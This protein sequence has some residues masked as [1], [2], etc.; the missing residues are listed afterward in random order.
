[1]K[2]SFLPL[3]FLLLSCLVFRSAHAQTIAARVLDK[4]GAPLYGANVVLLDSS[5]SKLVKA[6]LTDSAG[7][8][9]IASVAE[10]IYV[11]RAMMVGYNTYTSPKIEIPLKKE[12]P[13]IIM[14]HAEMKE[15][16]VTHQKPFIEVKPDKLIVN[17][18]NSI[19]SAGGT[20]L[21]IL[22]RSPGVVV[23]QNDNISLKGKGGVNVMIDG[24]NVPVSAA[25]LANMLKN[26]PANSID[27]IEI[28]SNPSARYDAEGNGIINIVT[29]KGQKLGFNGSVNAS[30][31]RGYYHK[32]NTG[33][34][35]NYRNEKISLYSNY[36]YSDREGFNHLVLTRRYY[37]RKA[38]ESPF[39]KYDQDHDAVFPFKTHSAGGG[40]DYKISS[41][42]SVGFG[43]SGSLSRLDSRSIVHST[44]TDTNNKV[45]SSFRTIN[46]AGSRW[47][48][49][50]A[51]AY[52]KHTL[53]STGKEIS[54]DMDYARYP[55]LN[56]QQLNTDYFNAEGN[57]SRPTYILKGDIEGYTQI[58]AIKSDYVHPLSKGRRLEA[59]VKSSYVITDNEPIFHD[60]SNAGAPIY[61]TGKSNHYIYRE[62]INAAYVNANKDGEKWSYQLGL[63]IEQTILKGEQLIT[64]DVMRRNYA[65][66]FP[67]AAVQRTINQSHTLGISL[68]RRIQRP[69]YD[70][71]NPFRYYMD[72]STFTEG[73]PFLV[74]EISYSA[75]LSH[76]FKQ[77]FVTSL[78]YSR[79]K[80]VI[81]EVLLPYPGN[82]TVQTTRNISTRDYY[83][84]SGT[85]PF[86]VYKWW[87]AMVNFN[88]YYS[89]YNGTFENTQLDRGMPTYNVYVS[90]KLNLPLCITGEVS[91]IYNAAQVYGFMEMKPTWMLN[92][93]LS[94]NF[95][96]KKG[97]IRLNATDIFWRGYPRAVSYYSNYNE[98]F[99]AY[100]DTRVVTLAVTY[101][102][103]KNTVAPVRQRE[104]GVQEEKNRVGS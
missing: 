57:M 94:R 101:R 1:M 69:N 43:L 65:R 91:F 93:G 60:I 88:L 95:L 76:T 90:N 51:N 70:Q 18:E 36:N 103:G 84:L 53:D 41:K 78:S 4:D 40:L 47:G 30:Y 55:S 79:T 20:V 48:N 2:K 34:S 26:M 46:D 7:R 80:D 52:L 66:L 96:D 22:G 83:S 17:V 16:V 98:N 100:R 71:L 15:V 37:T 73:N 92:A 21:E 28:I 8:F 63:R 87:S 32:V 99:V 27:R 89:H 81:T 24:R 9:S 33:V 50:S 5:G 61:D 54:V 12:M 10:G 85:Y 6:S 67:S 74:P 59:G 56:N 42:T 68:S 102:F 62:N 3:S 82:I 39:S 29:K 58:A 23:D 14:D 19:V 97:T 38:F 25:D 35:I 75:E 77:R 11:L 86:Q 49:F 104:S 64:H 45:A 13:N 44:E 72:P 31:G